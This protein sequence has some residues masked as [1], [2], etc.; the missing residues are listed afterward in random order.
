MGKYELQWTSNA[1]SL[2]GWGVRASLQTHGAEEAHNPPLVAF[3]P[4]QP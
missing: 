2:H 4:S 3:V 1:Y